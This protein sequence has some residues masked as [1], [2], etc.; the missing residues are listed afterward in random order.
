V[1]GVGVQRLSFEIV[2]DRVW[3]RLKRAEPDTGVTRLDRV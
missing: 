1:R 2:M 3:N